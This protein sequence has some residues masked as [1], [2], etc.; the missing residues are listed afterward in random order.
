MVPA[1]TAHV[2]FVVLLPLLSCQAAGRYANLEAGDSIAK[3]GRIIPYSAVRP[4]DLGPLKVTYDT[5][6]MRLMTP[7]PPPGVHPRILLSPADREPLRRLYRD[8]P[9]GRRMWAMLV[10][11]CDILKGRISSKDQC[12]KNEAGEMLAAYHRSG[13]A[14]TAEQYKRILAGNLSGYKP[15]MNDYV[16]GCMAIEAY[17]CWIEDDREAGAEL[18]KA[19]VNIAKAVKDKIEPGSHV[20][21]IGAYN[22]G[23][24]YD[25]AF[26]FMTPEQRET[27][28]SVI[29]AVSRH[30]AHYGAYLAPEAT[31]SNWCTLDSF[32]PLTLL[33]IEG[34]PGFNEGY[35][36][37]WVR[38][39]HN[40]I[41]YG[42]YPSGCP[43]EGL[44]K[45]YMFVTT[46]FALAKRGVNLIGHP[47]LRAYATK[48]L[49]AITLPWRS[50]FVG[51]DDWGG[52][53]WDT[54]NGN[55]RFN[56]NDVVGL[57]WLLP[58]DPA[59][60]YVWRA[61]MGEN[62]ERYTDLRPAGYYNSA[63]VTA[64]FPSG[65]LPG[66][67]DAKRA[68]VPLTYF[69]P[70]QG[71]MVTRSDLS[72]DALYL[73]LF[74]RQD[75]GGHTHANRN[76]IMFAGLGRLWCPI[77]TMAGGSRYG[78]IVETRFHSC[79]LIDGLGQGSQGGWAPQPGRFILLVDEPMATFGVGDAKY[80][81]DWIWR[82]DQS[83]EREARLLAEGWKKVGETPNDFAY[84]KS[85]LPWMNR[86]WYDRAH[87]LVPGEKMRTL[88][89]PWNPVTKAFRTAGIVR[90][91]HP[92][93]VIVDDIGK[94]D[95][96]LHLYSWLMQ[97]SDDLVIERYLFEKDSPIASMLIGSSNPEDTR[98]LLVCVLECNT[99]RRR[100][101]SIG[102]VEQYMGN[103]RWGAAHKRLVIPAWTTSPDYKILLYPHRKGQA[104]P[105]IAWNRQRTE[106]TVAWKDQRDTIRFEPGP[107]GRTVMSIYRNNQPLC[108]T[109]A[110]VA[111]RRR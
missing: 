21:V 71:L 46:V 84:Q 97:L 53:G 58:E 5:T 23:F 76:D 91:K 9:Y 50:G 44:G 103:V 29:A 110:E 17:R 75:L 7:V 74:C 31:T 102:R 24:C 40:F 98:K 62:Y 16:L 28:R 35:Y 41:T 37:G 6:G 3:C 8:T 101:G 15:S 99:D 55:Y 38:A 1:R 61:Y 63:L 11:W 70:E 22:M 25:F 12:P 89:K 80:A 85:P 79:I 33:A 49:P 36:K 39:Y 82:R 95:N 19:I 105:Q 47:H 54:V 106:A 45:N 88:K 72:D 57:K 59:V 107:D 2:A 109:A 30:K 4:D 14:R 93:A 66:P 90:G 56:I 111:R 20:G 43:Y 26:D 87:W 51:Y 92:Y 73:H 96:A 60:D 64:M 77:L 34:E 83:P 10:G 104:L 100:E 108:T 32:L 81:Y 65:P 69:A 52:T 48:F 78:N 68:G 67:T 94:P 18:A 86:P 13:F 42:W 27:V